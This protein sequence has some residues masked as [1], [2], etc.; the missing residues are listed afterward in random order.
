MKNSLIILFLLILLVLIL[1]SCA[2]KENIF[3]SQAAVIDPCS[4]VTNYKEQ[5]LLFSYVLS[6]N[7]LGII[8]TEE[9]KTS[10]SS[11]NCYGESRFLIKDE[12]GAD[13]L[14]YGFASSPLYTTSFNRDTVYPL[15]HDYQE[16]FISLPDFYSAVFF[17]GNY[18]GVTNANFK[19][20]C[21]SF[22]KSQGT[23]DYYYADIVLKW[24]N[25]G[26]KYTVVL[27]TIITIYI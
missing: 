25:S 16:S 15:L 12:N 7:S 13:L 22:I 18:A 6:E 5:D 24:E 1:V 2:K 23:S 3:P 19:V 9:R 20:N 17:K 11:N 10:V 8:A 14:F 21:L 26:K 4:I 27:K